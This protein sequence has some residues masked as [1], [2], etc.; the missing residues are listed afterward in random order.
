MPF[1]FD[2]SETP[3]SD[4]YIRGVN[5]TYFRN[6]N[7]VTYK[8]VAELASKTD[9]ILDYGAG[10]KAYHAG[11]LREMGFS[12]DAI[13]IGNNFN[14]EVHTI[15][16]FDKKYDVVYASN[17][18]NVQPN[19][20]YIDVVLG[21]IKSLLKPSGYFICNYPSDPRKAG[22]GVPQITAILKSNFSLVQRIPESNVPVFMCFL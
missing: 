18:I 1:K 7:A 13:D 9:K 14:P 17:V 10:P 5:K 22:L 3:Y 16:V 6:P 12:V 19:R 8:I 21:E 4:P 11:L 20:D 15:G 2:Y